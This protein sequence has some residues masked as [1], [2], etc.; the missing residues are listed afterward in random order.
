MSVGES[1]S[2]AL[3]CIMVV[4]AVL[5]CLYV[6]IKLFSYLVQTFEKVNKKPVA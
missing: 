3:F 6:V 4:F 1:V 5:L 2:I